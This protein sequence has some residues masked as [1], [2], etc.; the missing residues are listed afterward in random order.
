MI[1]SK[2]E[3]AELGQQYFYGAGKKKNYKRAF[4]HLLAA[5]MAGEPHCQNLVGYCYNRGLGVPKDL[6]KSLF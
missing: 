5:A 4:P 6:R 3:S 1:Y 2:E